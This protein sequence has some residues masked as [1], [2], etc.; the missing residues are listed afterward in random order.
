MQI[1]KIIQML[2]GTLLLFSVFTTSVQA[3]TGIRLLTEEG[4]T[5]Y[6]RTN[7]WGA[8]DLNS[9]VAAIPKGYHFR[10]LTPDGNNGKQWTGKYNF[11]GLDALGKDVFIDGMNEKGLAVG[12]FYHKGF[13]HY[14]EYDK[15]KADN[16]I[17][18]TDMVSYILSQFKNVDQVKKAL[19]HIRVVAVEEASLG[20][21]AYAHWMV[22]ESSG[23]SIVIEYLDGK[24]K[25]YKN[26]LG[27]ITNNPTYDW[28]MTNL[29]NYLNLS[30]EPAPSRKIAGVEFTPLSGGSG[31]V[32]LPGDF[33]ST[34]RFVRA[35]VWSHTD[36]PLKNSNDAVYELFRILDNFNVP[37]KS[38]EG[39]DNKEKD[40]KGMRSSTQWTTAWDLKHQVLYF[41]TQYN[42]RIREVALNKI[43]FVPNTITHTPMDQN[44][45]QDIQNITEH[46]K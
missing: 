30:I 35:A 16:T 15:R 24:L 45:R 27:V 40:V 46:L 23:K 39:S 8:F 6:G 44:K 29:R 37:L 11:V 20:V 13:A 3:C 10:G 31:M 26:P 43:K 28:Q 1:K 17:T 33:T 36:Q 32:G 19:K 38:A 5:V 12:F 25:T 41:H 18:A 42:R 22:T 34:S 2:M 14:M 9:R 4:S 7:E 21:P